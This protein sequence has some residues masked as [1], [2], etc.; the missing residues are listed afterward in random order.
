MDVVDTLRHRERVVER[1]LSIGA[2][3][4]QLVERLREIYAGQGIEVS[5][6]IIERGVRD[7]RENRFAYTP[8]PPSAGRTLAGIY[9]SRGRWGRQVGAL[10]AIFAIA[11]VGYQTLVRGPEQ[12]RIAGLPGELQSIYTAVVDLAE[13]PEVDAEALAMLT[14][15]ERAF[16]LED[17]GGVDAAIADLDKLHGA[18]SSRYEIRVRIAP[19]E[20]SGVW[21]I[22]D[23]NPGAQNFYLVVEAVDPD[24]NRLVVP[25][26]NEEDS[27]TY[28]VR[29]WAQRVDE[30]T[31]QGVAED[32]ADDGIIQNAKLGEKRRGVLD[33][34]FREGVMAGAITSW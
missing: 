6:A 21:R 20:L 28:N 15:G 30:A 9:V 12:D 23:D 18:L 26:T 2:D 32:K 25:I 17:Y 16:E 14:D 31:F 24:G 8:T 10:V 19:G 33:P 1:A 7:L 11:I 27:R 3:D 5:D 13:A 34:E 22:P 4:A 29:R